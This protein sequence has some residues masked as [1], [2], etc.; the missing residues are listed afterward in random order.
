ML[1]ASLNRI[2]T[3]VASKRFRSLGLVILPVKSVGRTGEG[4]LLS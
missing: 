1:G 3:N 2:T 4:P